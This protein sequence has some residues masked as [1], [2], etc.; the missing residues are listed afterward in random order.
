L[1]IISPVANPRMFAN[2]GQK[3]EVTNM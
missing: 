2:I 1:Q 3:L